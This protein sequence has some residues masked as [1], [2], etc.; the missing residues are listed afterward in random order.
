MCEAY[1]GKVRNEIEMKL[2]N[3]VIGCNAHVVLSVLFCLRYTQ[4]PAD[5][6]DWYDGFL[7]DE[8]VCPLG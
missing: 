8:E 3:M 1:L 6:I 2:C 5:L 7:D 4:P